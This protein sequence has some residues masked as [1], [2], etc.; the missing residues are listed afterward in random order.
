MNID[1]TLK[2]EVP[3]KVLASIGAHFRKTALSAG[4]EAWKSASEEED[5]ITGDFFG[6]LRKDN[7]RVKI[8]EGDWKWSVDYRKLRGRGPG[9]EEKITGA[10]GII[11]VEVRVLGREVRFQKGMLFQA[12]KLGGSDLKAVVSQTDKMESL[13][14][15]GSA[16][17]LYGPESF[18][19]LDGS[20][21]QRIL[22]RNGSRMS[23]VRDEAQPIGDYIADRF[24][25]C[26][27]GARGLAYQ[28]GRLTLPDRRKV[29]EEIR[30]RLVVSVET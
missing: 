27:C 6:Q 16:V 4:R 19:A 23:D 10:D 3:E 21:L 30:H 29:E 20:E 24:L 7:V 2:S 1:D 26:F 13:V 9:A 17:F 14:K 18:M 25:G 12:K 5:S 8:P 28:N 11:E 22:G 15:Q